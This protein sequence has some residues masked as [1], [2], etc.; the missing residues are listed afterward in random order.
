M[1]GGQL[2]VQWG[3]V[4]VPTWITRHLP[5]GSFLCVYLSLLNI[6]LTCWLSLEFSFCLGLFVLMFLLIGLSLS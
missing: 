2:G 1:P 5:R 4:A 6:L 3:A